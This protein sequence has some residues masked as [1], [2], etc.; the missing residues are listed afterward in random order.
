MTRIAARAAPFRRKKHNLENFFTLTQ[1]LHNYPR[2][3]EF[4]HKM[5]E[6]SCK[7]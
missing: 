3:Q 6:K 7:G 5:K 4:A 1:H 2:I